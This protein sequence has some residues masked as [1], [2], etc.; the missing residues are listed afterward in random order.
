MEHGIHHQ[1]HM[2][3]FFGRKG[4]RPAVACDAV[5][6]A[7]KKKDLMVLLVKRGNAPYK[8]MWALPGGFMEWGESCEEAVA[9]EIHEE[10]GLKGLEFEQ[11]GAF[12]TPGR[13]PR[14]TVVSIVFTARA[15]AK[16]TRVKGGD[17]AAE[18][19]WFALIEC[20]R[21]AFDHGLVLRA[22]L[23]RLIATRPPVKRRTAGPGR[24]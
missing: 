19:K 17:D 8:G 15:A 10:T 18:A 5:I 13:D 12:S 20:P 7:Q 24:K 6:F 16:N 21:L 14:G 23:S 9:R 1:E 22:A 4:K 11:L 2:T 3:D